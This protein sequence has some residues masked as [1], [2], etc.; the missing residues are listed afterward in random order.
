MFQFF[1]EI[2]KGSTT[3]Q[4][5]PP[6]KVEVAIRVKNELKQSL[7]LSDLMIM[8]F[9]IL[10]LNIHSCGAVMTAFYNFYNN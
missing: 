2:I 1:G 7:S 8:I 6:T 4:I 10:S 3:F 9:W 5:W